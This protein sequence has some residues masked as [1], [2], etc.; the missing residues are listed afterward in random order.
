MGSGR[1]GE[2]AAIVDTGRNRV[3]LATDA[4][5]TRPLWRAVDSGEWGVASCDSALSRLGLQREMRSRLPP[6]AAL[7][8]SLEP[9]AELR[10]LRPLRR[11]PLPSPP[12]PPPQ[13]RQR[14]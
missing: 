3:V 2:L 1:L 8:L 10:T 9:P 4:F 7:E 6:N 14:W 11:F 13:Q 12:P 5:G